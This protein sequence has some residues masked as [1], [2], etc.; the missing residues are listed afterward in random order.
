MLEPVRDHAIWMDQLRLLLCELGQHD[1]NRMSNDAV[2]V[3]IADRID[4]GMLSVVPTEEMIERL[5]GVREAAM[6]S[7]TSAAGSGS[8]SSA[9]TAIAQSWSVRDTGLA[10]PPRSTLPQAFGAKASDDV[11][12]PRSHGSSGTTSGRPYNPERAGGPIERL[13]YRRARITP[14]G[15]AEVRIHTSR[16]EDFRPN[17]LMIERLERIAAGELEQTE[18]DLRYYTHERRELE[19]YRNLGIPDNV[20]PG[21]D[22]WNDTH[23]ATLEDFAIADKDPSGNST[24]YH[25]DAWSSF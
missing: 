23:T 9:T 13:D 18:Y 12:A 22:V 24:L 3:A 2:L 10:H 4:L 8:T 5:F 1:V 20:D 7:S 14:E 15:I 6:L 16:F 19:R 21:Y 25:P 11:I 17:D